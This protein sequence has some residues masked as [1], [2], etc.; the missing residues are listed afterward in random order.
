[1]HPLRPGNSGTKWFEWA[2]FAYS[3]AVLVC[4]Q[5]FNTFLSASL[6]YLATLFQCMIGLIIREIIPN[7]ASCS[8]ISH[9]LSNVKRTLEEEESKEHSFDQNLNLVFIFVMIFSY[10]VPPLFSIAFMMCLYVLLLTVYSKIYSERLIS[11][12]LLI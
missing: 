3:F 1:L 4:F 10:Q 11:I 9:L 12:S 2:F 7:S 6:K 5:I 8:V